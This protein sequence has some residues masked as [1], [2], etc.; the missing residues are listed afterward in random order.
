MTV[1]ADPE[2][3]LKKGL[4]LNMM[5]TSNFIVLDIFTKR[6]QWTASLTL[7]VSKLQHV[8]LIWLTLEIIAS[9][10]ST[11]SSM[12]NNLAT[13]CSG[14]SSTTLTPSV[15]SHGINTMLARCKIAAKIRNIRVM[16]WKA[17]FFLNTLDLLIKHQFGSRKCNRQYWKAVAVLINC[18]IS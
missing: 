10:S 17:R 14:Y 15:S 5:I 7:Y 18:Q 1:T 13:A 6:A 9:V 11:S 3:T 16:C 2:N 4:F 8:P 12:P